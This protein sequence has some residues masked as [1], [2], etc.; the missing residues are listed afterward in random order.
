MSIKESLTKKQKISSKQ[1]IYNFRSYNNFIKDEEKIKNVEYIFTWAYDDD[2][3]DYIDKFET[4]K[5]VINYRLI[6][7]LFML[8]INNDTT[9]NPILRKNAKIKFLEIFSN[10]KYSLFEN[11]LLKITNE[12]PIE[13]TRLSVIQQIQHKDDDDFFKYISENITFI[14]I[15]IR[16]LYNYIHKDIEKLKLIL[17]FT[18]EAINNYINLYNLSLSSLEDYFSLSKNTNNIDIYLYRGFQ[19]S[20]YKPLLNYIDTNIDKE[21]ILIPCILSTS[22]YE[23]IAYNFLNPNDTRKIVWKIKIPVKHFNKFKYSYVLK[24][25]QDRYNNSIINLTNIDKSIIK[26]SEFI[27]NYGIILKFINKQIILKQLPGKKESDKIELYEFEFVDYDTSK[28][29]L[30]EFNL[31]IT[32]IIENIKISSI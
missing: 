5:D 17:N 14:P 25:Y 1:I 23:H 26:E 6:I 8:C 12:N 31:K 24:N 29:L 19:Y 18:K 15:Y 3:D 7:E 30:K 4:D 13:D 10:K 32:K 20:R 22:I 16:K 9:I 27:L 11:Y 28:D 21:E 2:I